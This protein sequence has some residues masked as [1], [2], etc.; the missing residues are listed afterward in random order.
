MYE[1]CVAYYETMKGIPAPY[2]KQVTN[3]SGYYPE[4]SMTDCFG[5]GGLVY[6]RQEFA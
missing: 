6:R 1:K 3:K 2:S 5:N 4:G